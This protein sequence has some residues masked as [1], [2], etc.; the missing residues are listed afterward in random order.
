MFLRIRTP[1]MNCAD[2]VYNVPTCINTYLVFY[3]MFY[4]KNIILS[5]IFGWFAECGTQFNNYY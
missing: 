5:Y 4:Y 1:N 2:R 3:L